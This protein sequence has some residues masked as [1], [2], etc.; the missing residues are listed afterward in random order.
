[1]SYLK[2]RPIN[3][4]WSTD[5]VSEESYSKK[6]PIDESWLTNKV[7]EDTVQYAEK[8]AQHLSEGSKNEKIQA[9]T[10]TQLRKFFGAVKQLQMNVELYGYQESELVMLK[11]KLAYAAGRC[12]KN[13][14]SFQTFKIDDFRE[15]IDKAIDI[16]NHSTDKDLAFKNFIQ[17]FEAIVAYHK[18]YG[19]DN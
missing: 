4:S 11:P 14:S 9:L 5:K 18:V 19:Q 16:V 3:K 10:T 1:M 13:N 15:V 17:F 12:H 8:L 7:T 6:H 2:E